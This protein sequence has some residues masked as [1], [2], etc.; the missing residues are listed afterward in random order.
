M[1]NSVI[2]RA[3][4]RD[5][6]ARITVINSRAI[7][8]KAHELHGTSPT[9]TAAL[10]RLLSATSMISAM[11]GEKEDKT[12]IVMN[13]DACRLICVGDYYGNVKGYIDDPTSDPPRHA[14]GKL[15]VGALIGHG[16]LSVIRDHAD[17]EPQSG[18]VEIRSGEVA[19]DIAAY[20]AESE[21]IPT[22]CA[23]GVLV[24]KDSS[25]LAS[26]GVLVQLLPFADEDTVSII[27][28]NAAA[29]EH[30]SE[31]FNRGLSVREVADIAFAGI[32]YDPF[33]EREVGYVCDCSR[34][35]MLTK[36]ASLG[37]R[38]VVKMLD[39]QEAEGKARALEAHCHF[40]SKNYSFTESELLDAVRTKKVR[41]KKN[42][43]VI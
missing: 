36:I 16:T 21:Q 26:G 14:N 28:K 9:A 33:D 6:S 30:V 4:T 5:G 39:E 1:E 7:T 31:L 29:L 25:C 27:E 19:E 3:M 37:E 24:D 13:G 35:R 22:L 32:P 15:N 42:I 10:G 40:C 2:F 12:T 23:L 11:M 34:E 8:Q 17:R 41:R 20:F 18:M 38:E 43:K